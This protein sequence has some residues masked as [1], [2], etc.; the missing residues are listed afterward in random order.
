MTPLTVSR[1]LAMNDTLAGGADND[2][3]VIGPGRPDMEA[4]V[5]R[6]GGVL[7]NPDSS[8]RT[9]MHMRRR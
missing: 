1:W 5:A 2:V 4:H 7:C 6:D 8:A 3:L 9:R